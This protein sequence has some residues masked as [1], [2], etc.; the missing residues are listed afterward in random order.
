LQDYIKEY[1]FWGHC[2]ID[3][4]FGNIRTFITDEI[5]EN[6]F[7]ILEHGHFTLYRN[8]KK[9]NT[10]FMQGN[11]YGDYEY[12]KVYTSDDSL[13]FDECLGTQLL[14]RKLK[15]ATYCKRSIF[16]DVA[17]DQKPFK[18]LDGTQNVIFKYEY[19]KLFALKQGEQRLPVELMYAHFQ[20]RKMDYSLFSEEL[21]EFYIVPNRLI[22]SPIDE[23]KLFE[24]KGNLQYRLY[25]KWIHIKEYIR[26]YRLGKYKSFHAYRQERKRLHNDIVTAKRI[27][28]NWSEETE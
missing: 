11:G 23:N 9:T 10:L 25:R 18:H 17:T 27:V 4:I 15:I 2:D 21:K 22:V 12:K 1:D 5:L 14:F 16:F 8:D 26:R 24:C 6:N 28:A 7:K 13:Y 19:G 3:L 20:K